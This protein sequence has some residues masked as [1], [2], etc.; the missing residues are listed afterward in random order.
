MIRMR[1]LF[2][3]PALVAT[4]AFGGVACGSD[5]DPSGSG[6]DSTVTETAGSDDTTAAPES[7]VTEA[8]TTTTTLPEPTGAPTPAD[9][10]LALYGAWEA[11][12]RTAAADVAE[13]DAIDA[14]WTAIPGPYELYRHC[15]DGD[16]DTSGCLFRDRSTNHTIQVSLERRG[17]AW[18][19]VGAFFSEE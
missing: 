14:F 16:F 7:T 8:E 4:L 1:R 12:D 15:D 5:D 9:A 10:A 2:I 19:V 18:V 17:E 6:T 11:D 13:P 3:V